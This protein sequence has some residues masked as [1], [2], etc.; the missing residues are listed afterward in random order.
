MRR[1][2]LNSGRLIEK[3]NQ[4]YRFVFGYNE[5][6]QDE[7]P[8]YNSLVQRYHHA[9]VIGKTG[10][11]KSTLLEN[12]ALYDINY[13]ASVI[14]IDPSGYSTRKLYHSIQDKS[15]VRYISLEMPIKVNLLNKEGYDLETIM[16]EFIQILDVMITLTASN[17]ESTTMMRLIIR[18]AILA[19]KNKDRDLDYVNKLLID[20][21][22]RK[23][24]L[25]DLEQ[26]T[27]VY[28]FWKTFDDREN[29]QYRE[30]AQRTAT[31]LLEITS[32]KMRDF[33]IKKNKE[34][35]INELNM[36]DIAENG[37]VLLVDTSRMTKL[38]QIYLSSLLVYSVYSYCD[39][40]PNINREPK[41]QKA[42]LIYVDEFANVVS[43]V[44]SDLLFRA[45]KAGFGFT[46]AHQNFSQIKREH[47]YIVNDAIST[48]WTLITFT[49]GLKEAEALA[50]WYDC[51]KKDLINLDP[52]MAW[53]RIQKNV[54]LTALKKP[55]LDH[56][57]LAPQP[58]NFLGDTT[59]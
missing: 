2:I 31:R 40:T 50:P 21:N 46:F 24:V 58:Y 5:R 14:F 13:G 36:T 38:G 8:E 44:F 26:G 52:H 22:T 56:T 6:Y 9:Y 37:K 25:K 41:D 55:I 11:G 19:I 18:M 1:R 7:L 15:R 51:D 42:L 59:F 39:Y 12:M 20:K 33:T 34:E 16:Q 53:I 32:G 54:A 17:P 47:E 4:T 35:M 45:R 48:V 27:E 57:P 30:S 49:C 23:N 43:S 29:W 28:E 3:C 10:A